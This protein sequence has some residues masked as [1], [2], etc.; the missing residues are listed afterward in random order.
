MNGTGGGSSL[1]D[2][3]AFHY[4]SAAFPVYFLLCPEGKANR[5]WYHPE[6][7]YKYVYAFVITR[8]CAFHAGASNYGNRWL[9]KEPF[10]RLS[11]FLPLPT[12]RCLEDHELVV[13]VQAAMSSEGRFVFRK[14]YAK[15]EFFKNP[16]V[17]SSS[18]QSYCCCLGGE[19]GIYYGSNSMTYL[20]CLCSICWHLYSDQY[21]FWPFSRKDSTNIL[22]YYFFN[23]YI[24]K[25][26]SDI[27]STSTSPL[28]FIIGLSH[29]CVWIIKSL[30]LI[31][32]KG[33][34]TLRCFS[35]SSSFNRL[36]WSKT[37]AIIFERF[38]C[39]GNVMVS[40]LPVL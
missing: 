2:K 24:L 22:I 36:K 39:T 32:L 1:P 34:L 29:R 26:G 40:N 31:P 12:E 23:I 9:C 17:S 4:V 18:P 8:G 30:M 10:S 35:P 21:L 15:Y 20:S 11:D 19:G 7:T 27:S 5:R 13:H 6:C 16:L 25:S 3:L 37:K 14:N 28:Q 38:D 33:S